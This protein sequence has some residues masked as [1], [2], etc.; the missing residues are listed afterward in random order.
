MNKCFKCGTEYEGKFCPDCGAKYEETKTCPQCG[1]ELDGQVKFCNE[2]GYSF[3]EQAQTDNVA[4]VSVQQA[5]A[6]NNNVDAQAVMKAIFTKIK[7]SLLKYAPL[8]MFSLWAVL[9]WAFYTAKVTTDPFGMSDANLFQ[10]LKDETYTDLFPVLKA[11]L[12]FAIIS[13]V[14]IVV[15]VPIQIKAA[16]KSRIITYVGGILLQLTVLICAI[17]TKYKVIEYSADN[18]N[19]VTILASFTGVFMGLEILYLILI[20]PYELVM[21]QKL[22][23]IIKTNLY[24]LYI[25]L[26]KYELVIF[27]DVTKLETDKV[28]NQ[29]HNYVRITVEEKNKNYYSQ[30]N[31][32][33]EKSTNVLV[34]GCMKSV[35]PS[36]GSVVILGEKAFSGCKKLKTIIIPKTVQA[37]RSKCFEYC[38][39]LQSITYCGTKNDWELI[40]KN[41]EWNICSG[42]KRIVCSDGIIEA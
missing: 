5:I 18:G 7:V 22:S 15:L 12:S 19:F 6:T 11:L 16:D 38:H 21:P 14:Y 39:R 1:K 4:T 3:V 30:G 10:A 40:T 8:I 24:E 25:T 32:I 9:L 17:I 42:I 37:I 36:D 34:L 41:P 20:G 2:C 29:R 27:E 33:I 35:I 31:C 26:F 13:N 23:E 28:N